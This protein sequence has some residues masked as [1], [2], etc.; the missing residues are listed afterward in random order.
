MIIDLTN[1]DL[2]FFPDKKFL[3]SR[4]K[5]DNI[6][7]FNIP[8]FSPRN[9]VKGF[10]E[11]RGIAKPKIQEVMLAEFSSVDMH[12]DV[13]SDK[14]CG[15][16]AIFLKG[17]GELYQTVKGDK[18]GQFSVRNDTIEVNQAITFDFHLPHQFKAAE[19]CIAVLAD[20]NRKQLE[21][22]V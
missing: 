11:R 6:E 7:P 18:R 19:N 20:V 15:T 12:V 3:H 4:Y 13:L 14:S 22:L 5:L 8:E 9:F 10:L 2:L 17:G 21:R 16:I 1:K